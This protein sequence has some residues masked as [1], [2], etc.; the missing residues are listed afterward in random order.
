MAE[1]SA[2]VLGAGVAGLAATAALAQ[3]GYSVKLLEKD[4]WSEAA[5]SRP[6]VP[7]ARQLHNILGRAQTELEALAPGFMEVLIRDGAASAEAAVDTFVVEYQT[8]MPRRALGGRLVSSSRMHIENVLRQCVSHEYH[9]ALDYGV[10]AKGPL[11]EGGRVVGVDTGA[12]AIRADL[13][14]DAMGARSPMLQWLKRVDLPEVRTEVIPVRQWYVSAQLE[15]PASHRG[16][17]TFWLIFPSGN[18][19]RG[20]L[21]SPH[22]PEQWVVSLSGVEP[23]EPPQ[24]AEEMLIHAK[25]LDDSAIAELLETSDLIEGPTLFRKHRARW[26]HVE[27]LGPHLPGLLF[28]GDSVASLNPL[29]GQGMSVAAW[30][31]RRIRD[32]LDSKAGPPSAALTR[33]LREATVHPVRAALALASLETSE[34]TSRRLREV[35][36]QCHE[37]AAL[38]A[39][40]FRMWHLLEAPEVVL[41]WPAISSDRGG[42]GNESQ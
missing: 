15:R 39:A 34:E 13:V 32:R 19:T 9:P 42:I 24:T 10:T 17:N 40:T 37:D 21:V 7:Q 2:V 20:G 14:I 22:G 5:D 38:H 1:P 35:S 3:C 11:V 4:Q 8:Q 25:Q 33:E 29:L 31:A 27:D 18:T 26:N 23:D 41:N 12:G 6:G 30:Q 36:R 28:V 16:D